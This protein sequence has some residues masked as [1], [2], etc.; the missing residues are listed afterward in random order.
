MRTDSMARWGAIFV[1][2]LALPVSAAATDWRAWKPVVTIQDSG[3]AN[4]TVT[5]LLFD[6]APPSQPAPAGASIPVNCQ[7][8]NG[9]GSITPAQT[10]VP[11]N[12]VYSINVDVTWVGAY[13]TSGLAS[14]GRCTF[15]IPPMHG[16][17]GGQVV[18]PFEGVSLSDYQIG[19]D[20]QQVPSGG[21]VTPGRLVEYTVDV[22]LYRF[23]SGDPP[24]PLNPPRP[25]KVTGLPATGFPVSC[26]VNPS[27]ATA[28]VEWLPLSSPD[29]TTGEYRARMRMNGTDIPNVGLI[30]SCTVTPPAS[31]RSSSLLLFPPDLCNPAVIPPLAACDGVGI[32]PKLRVIVRRIGDAQGT[33]VVSGA[34]PTSCA[35]ACN[36]TA[37]GLVTIIPSPGA[38]VKVA[39]YA[40][41]CL[42]AGAGYA[43]SGANE[44][45]MRPWCFPPEPITVDRFKTC[46]VT[47]APIVPGEDLSCN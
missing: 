30:G 32:D 34:N 16:E 28:T 38:N 36:H 46:E 29:V 43:G 3:A 25:L 8:L 4:R 39:Q 26:T 7:V 17:V 19:F 12:G 1:A 22:G 24:Q 40:G 10:F 18:V 21:L 2:V 31:A 6:P 27:G 45:L 44:S 14:L 23:S 35:D 33:V 9:V 20:R 11:L 41:D 47:F 13:R 15:T 37:T 42:P 5:V